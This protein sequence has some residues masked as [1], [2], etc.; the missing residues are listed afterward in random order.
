VTVCNKQEGS[1]DRQWQNAASKTEVQTDSD[2]M[3]Q[4]RQRYRQTVTVC[5][6]QEKYRQTVTVCSKQDR[7][8][9]RE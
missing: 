5:S 8:T 3:Q 6:K 1:R 9:D 2:S 4:A 7:S